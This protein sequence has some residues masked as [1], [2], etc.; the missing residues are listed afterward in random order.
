VEVGTAV[1]RLGLL[2]VLSSW[3]LRGRERLVWREAGE[4]MMFRVVLHCVYDS[5]E[6]E[7][8]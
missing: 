2:C 6:L 1:E 8:A 5:V 3:H 7:V 4:G